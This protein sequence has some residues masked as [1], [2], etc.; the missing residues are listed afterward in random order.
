MTDKTKDR[1]SGRWTALLLTLALTLAASP[2]V[3][4]KYFVF[5][6]GT[7]QLW[8]NRDKTSPVLDPVGYLCTDGCG[9]ESQGMRTRGPIP[10]SIPAPADT[11][12]WNVI[13]DEYLVLVI[14]EHNPTTAS[15]TT[16]TAFSPRC[17]WARHGNTGYYYQEV[18]NYMYYL[19]ASSTNGLRVEVLAKGAAIYGMTEWFDWDFG[20]AIEE[21]YIRNG[22]TEKEYYWLC[23][24]G[25]KWTLS[26]NSYNRPE[27]P[28]YL[29]AAILSDKTYYCAK[30]VGEGTG[31]TL[32]PASRA[33]QTAGVKVVRYESEIHED[34][35][36][37]FTGLAVAIG[38]GG[39]EMK[40]NGEAN[41]ATLTLNSDF[42][43]GTSASVNRPRTEYHLETSRVGMNLNY[44]QRRDIMGE[45]VEGYGHNGTGDTMVY[46]YFDDGEVKVD[47]V[48][49]SELYMPV[50]LRKQDI[51]KITYSIDSR[52]RR[53]LGIVSG[54]TTVHTLEYTNGGGCDMDTVVTL[55]CTA[56]PNNMTAKVTVSVHYANGVVQTRTVNVKLKQEYGTNVKKAAE[57]GPLV[58]GYVVGGGRMAGIEGNTAVTVHNCDSV[59]AIYGGNDIAGWVRG[60]ATVRIGTA[61]T[62]TD[63]EYGGGK[64]EVHVGYVYGGGCGFYRYEGV[65]FDN[66]EGGEKYAAY[67]ASTPNLGYHNYWFAGR[68][69]PWSYKPVG[70]VF[71]QDSAVDEQVF[72]FTPK[73]PSACGVHIDL[74][75][76]GRGGYG[77]VPYVKK[78]DI[79]V[80]IDTTTADSLATAA[81]ESDWHP[82]LHKHNDYIHVDSIFGGAENSFIGVTATDG[83]PV[84]GTTVNIN[85]GTIMSVYGGNNYGG[86]VAL[87]AT[88][89]VNVYHTKVTGHNDIENS[90][91]T[92]YGR[93]FGIRHVFGGGNLVENSHSEVNIYGGMVDTVFGGGNRASVLRP[94]VNVNCENENFIYNN[95]YTVDFDS[96][97]YQ[98]NPQS[99]I[100][101]VDAQPGDWIPDHGRYNVRC[102]FGGNNKAPMENLSIV[103]LLSGG[104]GYVYGGGNQ[105]DML[106]DGE[107]PYRIK[108]I[109]NK[110]DDSVRGRDIFAGTVVPPPTKV[111]SIVYSNDQS[112]IIVENLYGGCRMSNVK[113]SCGVNLNGG[114]FGFIQGGCDIS[115]HVGAGT[116][117]L[118]D[119]N[120][121]VL[122]DAYGGS[123]GY[124]HC[125]DNNGRYMEGQ[126]MLN[127]ANEPW[128]PYDDYVGMKA[129]THDH[130]NVLMG[131]GT[132]LGNLYGGAVSTDVGDKTKKDGSVHLDMR[133][134]RVGMNVYGGGYLSSVHGNG[135]VHI[136]GTAQ[137]DGAV[138]AGNDYQGTIESFAPF[139]LPHWTGSSFERKE[140]F[141]SSD[142][143]LLNINEEGNY[144]ANFSSYLLIDGTPRIHEVYGSGNGAYDYDGTRPEYESWSICT[145]DGDDNRPL[146]KSTFIDINTRGGYID[147]VYGGGNG[148]GVN[149]NVTVLLNTQSVTNTDNTWA[150]SGLNHEGHFVG[151]IFGGNNRDMMKTCVP[152]VILTKGTVR[153]VYGGS[154]AG[155]MYGSTVKKDLCGNEVYGVSTYV[156]VNSEDVTITGD[157][158]GGCNMADVSGM[159]YIDI[160]KTSAPDPGD[161]SKA[162]GIGSV[163]GGNNI[164]GDV[165]GNTRID[166]NG[167]H[168]KNIYGGSNGY[169][170]YEET[171]DGFNIFEYGHDGSDHAIASFH[172]GRP[173]VTTTAVNIYGGTIYN[174]VYGGGR[175]GDCETTHVVV[176][177][178]QCGESNAFIYGTVYGG[179]E[180][181]HHDL[182]APRCGNVTED[183]YVDL[184]HAERVTDAKAYG[185]GRGG[186]VNNT[187]ITIHEAWDQPFDELYGG[188]WGSDVISTAHVSVSGRTDIE[189]YNVETLFGGN[190]FTGNVYKSIV[191]IHSGTFNNI[192]GAGNGDYES[193]LYTAE[194]YNTAGKTLYV[195]NNEYV[196]VN[197]HDGH[198]DNNI[199]GGG[200]MGTTFSYKKNAEG[201]YVLVN[202][203]KVADTALTFATAHAD[204]M[205]YSLIQVNMHGGEVRSNIYAGAAGTAG[206]NQLV[207]GLKMLN[208][209]GGLVGTSIYGGSENVNDG[210]GLAGECDTLTAAEVTAGEVKPQE[211]STMRPSSILNITGGTIVNN[212]YGGGYLG[213]VRGSIYINVGLTAIDS[214]PA[215][216]NSYAET[217]AAYAL[218]KPGA[219]DGHVGALLA[220]DLS[221]DHSIYGG[222]NWGT[223]S[224]SS[225]FNQRGFYGGENRIIVDGEGYNTDNDPMNQKPLI[226]IEKSIIGAGTSA[227]G[228]DIL[229]RIEVR[230]YGVFGGD[231][232]SSKALEAIQRANELWL[233][234]TAIRYT[235]TTDAIA[236]EVS[237]NYSINRIDT[238]YMRG[239]NIAETEALSTNIASLVFYEDALDA[240]YN[241]V[242]TSNAE[243][244]QHAVTN[245][246]CDLEHNDLCTRM[247]VVGNDAAEKRYSVLLI[248]SAD[249]F[250]V[251]K[252][253][254]N[255]LGEVVDYVY[256]SVYGFGYLMAPAGNN[257]VVQARFKLPVDPT[258]YTKQFLTSIHYYDG[259]FV[260]PCTE[261]TG[262]NFTVNS[263]VY[264]APG[265]S[266]WSNL[267]IAWVNDNIGTERDTEPGKYEFNYTDYMQTYR[268]WS[269]NKGL[270]RRWG[271]VLAHIN[272][273]ELPQDKYAKIDGNNLAVA[274]G[275]I[276]LPPTEPGHYYRLMDNSFVLSGDNENVELTDCAWAPNNWDAMPDGVNP[277]SH[278]PNGWEVN[279][280]P[281]NFTDADL[282][283]GGR[284]IGVDAI[285]AHPGNTFGL[286]MVPGSNFAA[287]Q[288]P[289]T[290]PTASSKAV[291][292]GN[293]HVNY[294]N[295][296]CTTVVNGASSSSPI[297]DLYLTYSN[298]FSN[299]FLGTVTFKFQEYMID[300][301]TG[302]EV[303]LD[304][305]IEIGII[306][307]TIIKDFT[308]M[309]HEVLAMY[310][311]G[312]TNVFSRK[313]VLPATLQHRELYMTSVK[314]IPTDENGADLPSG[315]KF[316]LTDKEETVTGAATDVHNIFGMRIIPSDNMSSAL[317]SSIGWHT[318]SEDTINVFDLAKNRTTAYPSNDNPRKYSDFVGGNV[319]SVSLADLNGGYG[320]KVGEL[321]GR[322]LAVLNV[323]LLF[324][325]NRIYDKIEGKGYVGK[326]VLGL[327]SRYAGA[328]VE[329]DGFNLTIYV[330][331]R[332]NG[333]TIYLASANEVHLGDSVF[334]PFRPGVHHDEDE[335]KWPNRYVQT[336][337]DALSSRVYQEGDVIAII[338]E[339]KITDYDKTTIQG[340]EY[341]TV[342]VIRYFGHN[343]LAAGEKYVYRGTMITVDGPD[344]V[345]NA[346]GISFDG[347]AFGKVNLWDR[348]NPTNPEHSV[349]VKDTNQAFGPI[350]AVK[351]RGTVTMSQG[352]TVMHNWNEYAGSDATLKGAISL[353]SGGTLSLSGNVTI[354]QNYSHTF[355][356][357]N[358]EKPL[359]GAVYIDGGVLTVDKSNEK[360]AQ[361]IT[362]N[363]LLPSNCMGVGCTVWWEENSHGTRYVQKDAVV[364]TWEKANVYL[365]RTPD[366]PEPILKDDQSD[367]IHLIS[368]LPAGTRIGIS[369]WFPGVD[370]RDTI[371]GVMQTSG[372]LTYIDKAFANQNFVSDDNYDIFYSRYVAGNVIYLHRCATF[373]QQI[374]TE[375]VIAGLQGQD[376]LTYKYNAAATCP[377]G[378]D[379][380]FYHV[381]GGFLPYTYDWTGSNTRHRLTQH[382]N[383]TI[384]EQ[385]QAGN[386]SGL[387]VA[388]VDTMAI[389]R[390]QMDYTKTDTTLKYTVLAMDAAG[391]RQ[392]KDIEV[393]IT[394]RL[395]DVDDEEDLNPLNY[396]DITTKNSWKERDTVTPAKAERNYSTIQLTPWVW[397]D[398]SMT[399]GVIKASVGKG[400]T[401]YTDEPGSE[402]NIASLR[403]CE[404]DVIKLAT[405]S[406]NPNVKFIMWDFDPYYKQTV[407]YMVPAQSTDIIAYY[408][409]KDYWKDTVKNT[410]IATAA[411]SDGYYYSRPSGMNYVTTYEGDVHIY[412]ENGLAWFISVV[413][414]LNGTQARQFYFNKVYLHKKSDGD[415]D[416]DMKRH[417]WTPVGTHQHPFS[418]WLIGVGSGDTDTVPLTAPKR[419][420]VKNIIV[421]EPNMSHTGFFGYVDGSHPTSASHVKSRISG[422]ELSSALV[423]GSQYVGT[424]AAS[425]NRVNID[426]VAV[427]DNA[428]GG[429]TATILT[430]HYVSGGMLGEAK[431]SKVTNSQTKAKYVGDAV[432]SGGIIGY[433]EN[434]TVNDSWARNDLRMS[435]LY[436]GGIAGNMTASDPVVTTSFLGRMLGIRRTAQTQSYIANN[437]IHIVDNGR[438]ERGGGVAGH[439][440]NT[441]MENNYVYGTMHGTMVNGGVAATM[442]N[443]TTTAPNYTEV[444]LGNNGGVNSTATFEGKG[445]QVMLDQEVQGTDNL[446]RALNKWVRSHNAAGATYNTWRSDLAGENNGYPLFGEPDLIPVKGETVVEGCD[447]VVWTDGNTYADGDSITIHIIDSVEMVDSLTTVR[448]VVHHSS[449]TSYS[450]SATMGQ[451]YTGYGFYIS[452]AETMLLEEAIRQNGSASITLADTLSGQYG[453]D[454][455]VTLTVHFTMS[456]NTG[457]ST[458][459]TT[460][461]EIKVYPNPTTSIVTVETEGLSHVELYDNEGRRLENYYAEQGDSLTIDVSN[462]SSGVYYLRVHTRD[463]INIQKLIKR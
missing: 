198:V 311:E 445:N 357:D 158:Y 118:L 358:A 297:M 413:N 170:D 237:Q 457:I 169:Y 22:A 193:S 447:E 104:V 55:K 305:P 59:Y 19:T 224:G 202:G 214:C 414:G 361:T 395:E 376:P 230:N 323:D 96:A 125:L 417:L 435:G 89:I 74:C 155:D 80:G 27:T 248:T 342:P 228:G 164:A 388:I 360:T 109:I 134:G 281:N 405:A 71:D 122:Q 10:V 240:N 110:A 130:T 114:T 291:I 283:A 310:N 135:Y 45:P 442:G 174:S 154:N 28:I 29:D 462:Y 356:G 234:N 186:D 402:Y 120:V 54:E 338:G 343:A 68:V 460:K 363:H 393:K 101:W 308:D 415:G 277:D 244:M 117:V 222:A 162:Y 217:A 146:Q 242:L 226:N 463:N 429:G 444:H 418:G 8:L 285:L 268:V 221:M 26:C 97:V 2:A 18:G 17:V 116:Y 377:T 111:S 76:D 321:D 261:N 124:Y 289:A 428:S 213:S 163:Y 233:H 100:N 11:T 99:I 16:G 438:S 83:D 201:E 189:G 14:D 355:A 299:T 275:R 318:I 70:G 79:H 345:F 247:E 452:R 5:T 290:H 391:C 219:T 380:L 232:Q 262:N 239:Y 348:E 271:T 314:W 392:K 351:N 57:H 319:S 390:V 408:G 35:T 303:S 69:Y 249:G 72:S 47:N 329:A 354:G 159:A 279:A 378:G 177:D 407:N 339:V 205:D 173:T 368:Q 253:V 128:D 453:C 335:G 383:I 25:T 92:G 440:D 352:T 191:D 384:D 81:G 121:V 179:G 420:V 379:T 433:G 306:I 218:F 136:G 366:G 126:Q 112:K 168:V 13:G 267:P 404:G 301:I 374:A 143:T 396:V 82:F 341:S 288:M 327:Q 3:A 161:L 450:D 66:D 184:Y 23:H 119:S 86:S 330:K 38:G 315:V 204:P 399:G 51:K 421:D 49:E 46:Y 270:R 150:A 225:N 251:K 419:V 389:P 375:E 256:G 302:N 215:W 456:P 434:D 436:Y 400:D 73:D 386:T 216:R 160:R 350:I 84:N 254:L 48:T 167:G 397:A 4:Q 131:G 422:I 210:Y 370:V 332:E 312:R 307:S 272:P 333:D 31:A 326:V 454:S 238:V 1:M 295:N 141:A 278:V 382:S 401:I 241:Y 340:L 108:K 337:Q 286:M 212:V 30:T 181:E 123:D 61:T 192:Y 185:G 21:K 273:D 43:T 385:L 7:T 316:K 176:D 336:F 439:A 263:Y 102:L 367:Y 381:Q 129:P 190:D 220:K 33:G 372:N 138:F 149:E 362:D 437:Y 64:K 269:V 280:N 206:G 144:T 211:K 171:T 175:M 137:V 36:G 151:T 127:Y 133:G 443:G 298:T 87:T 75:E 427:V 44:H 373:K 328:P 344:A 140:T 441:V 194:P 148:V 431:N 250:E 371:R 147:T 260:D 63:A 203:R 426:N 459:A 246:E 153:N 424:L 39:D 62:G 32:E 353:T 58:K 411:M 56:L 317:A 115:G 432:Y 95:P 98:D 410:E 448:F 406:T 6:T 274:H 300:P 67:L 287:S 52:G 325:G 208:M 157:L 394:K 293:S 425:A 37:A 166:V 93:D 152:D 365:T 446:T 403:F 172:T 9:G 322:G 91:Y 313:V 94:I 42:T 60:N 294:S 347:S 231:C 265:S 455:I 259:G 416:Y 292:S 258:G 296:Y 182:N 398:R 78:A 24:D 132:V 458:T 223:N 412:N 77:T 113:E 187:H 282:T 451:D 409:P 461:S 105:G 90:Y 53:Y 304:Q 199:Y 183:S 346:K 369:K 65:H 334:H 34:A 430:T 207:Y 331:T 387:K 423:R 156:L 165:N 200:K 197:F 243:L 40:Y 15:L 209:D 264:P 178:N 257:A 88:A 12:L 196:E 85:G 255:N 349:P 284:R 142:G 236:S 106:Y 235:G 180:G 41:T 229:S 227:N 20:A 50:E 245:G 266:S 309:E 276:I 107:L 145:R 364:N 324:D 359:N 188:C 449:T 195:P 320:L 139:E 252:D 103:N